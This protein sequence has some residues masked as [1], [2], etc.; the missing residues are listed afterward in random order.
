M[1]SSLFYLLNLLTLRLGYNQLVGPLPSHVSGLNLV[2]LYLS[3]NFLNET[4]RSWLFNMPSL[5]TLYLNGNQFV[6]EIGE[7]KYNS[8]KY[9]YLG[10]NKL[11]GSIP[12]SVSRLV[13]LT[14]L[15][16]SSINLSIMLG[17]EM[18]SKLENLKYLDF[19]NNS[20]SINNNFTYFLPNL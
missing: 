10:Y 12:R 20:V 1:P 3:S 14:S 5:E 7:F 16:L 2:D 8:L 9:L 4:L 18:F 17:L 15:S 6:G 19:S 11:H 13:N